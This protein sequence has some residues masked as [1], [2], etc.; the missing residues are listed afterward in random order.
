[1][2]IGHHSD[3]PLIVKDDGHGRDKKMGRGFL[4]RHK[5]YAAIMALARSF[6][7]AAKTQEHDTIQ[8]PPS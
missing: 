8:V 2:N 1:M 5:A 4:I 6:S 7:Q 3:R